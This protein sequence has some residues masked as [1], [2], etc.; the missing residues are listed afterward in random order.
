MALF[1]KSF[2]S[3]V[4]KHWKGIGLG[5][6]LFLLAIAWIPGVMKINR[7]V[8]KFENKELNHVLEQIP[9]LELK[10]G[11]MVTSAKLPYT[12][13]LADGEEFI[14][15]DR[16]ATAADYEKLD[17]PVLITENEI[18]AQ[19]SKNEKRIYNF[20]DLPD[21][22]IDAQVIREVINKALTVGRLVTYPLLVLNSFTARLLQ[23]LVFGLIGL[24]IAS[25]L[26]TNLSFGSAV[27]L[28]VVAMTASVIYRTIVFYF[29]LHVPYYWLTGVL[30]TVLFLFIGINAAE[31][32]DAEIDYSDIE[33][34]PY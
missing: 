10:D 21:I 19:K 30:L 17:V 25:V 13:D 1:S 6:L 12:I 27:R 5:Y 2:Y 15:I 3:S 22:V 9:P 14:R 7:M 18:I 11:K 20:S 4:A 16:D 29:G 34:D 28:S 8:S 33:A 32:D 26:N 31:G 24:I 23:A